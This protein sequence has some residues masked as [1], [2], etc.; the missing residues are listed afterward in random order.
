[1]IKLRQAIPTQWKKSLKTAASLKTKIK[2]ESCISMMNRRNNTQYLENLTNKAI[3]EL[4]IQ[5][6]FIESFCKKYWNDKFNILDSNTI[7]NMFS[8]IFSMEDNKYKIFK[9][10]LYNKILPNNELLHRWK[11]EKN[12]LCKVCNSIENYEHYFI[13]CKYFDILWNKV[14]ECLDI[15]NFRVNIRQLKYIVIGY[16]ITYTNYEEINVLLTLVGY[17]IYKTYHV[18]EQKKKYTDP[19]SILQNEIKYFMSYTKSKKVKNY[20][21]RFIESFKW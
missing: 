6:K 4:G 13:K 20:L 9:W 15:M 17:T 7:S 18:S 3:Y 21:S 14:T 10:K 2:K 11:I 16:K 5:S 1:M 19:V 12:N 8:F